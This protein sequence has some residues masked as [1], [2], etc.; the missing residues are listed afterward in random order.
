MANYSLAQRRMMALS[1][2]E[3]R[4]TLTL[5]EADEI[6]EQ[7]AEMDRKLAEYWDHLPEEVQQAECEEMY[8]PRPDD[9]LKRCIFC[10]Q[11]PA[12]EGDDPCCKEFSGGFYWEDIFEEEE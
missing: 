8:G 4:I 6:L 12:A 1:A 11:P 9:S 3:N 7:I 2:G 5:E 10:N